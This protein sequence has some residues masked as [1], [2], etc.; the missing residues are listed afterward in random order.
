MGVRDHGLSN[1]PLD[2]AAGQA[3]TA[4]PVTHPMDPRRGENLSPV[5]AAFLLADYKALMDAC[6]ARAGERTDAAGA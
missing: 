5:F 1:P 6:R 4:G 2:P 3:A